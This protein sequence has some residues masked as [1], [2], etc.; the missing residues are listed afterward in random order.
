MHSSFVKCIESLKQVMPLCMVWAVGSQTVLLNL[1][2]ASIELYC[3]KSRLNVIA[4]S[5]IFFVEEFRF[6]KLIFH[7]GR[8]VFRRW[9]CG[10]ATAAWSR[11]C[12]NRL[13]LCRNGVKVK[14]GGDFPILIEE[15]AAF[16]SILAN[17]VP[18]NN[19]ESF[20]KTLF[21]SIL[22]NLHLHDLKIRLRK[23]FSL[24]P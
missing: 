17:L 6:D 24:P 18:V 15:E 11:Y 1:Q 10:A 5:I 2:T 20:E 22:A 16:R 9:G 13:K 19:Y 4:I 12:A 14:Y 7:V 8:S 23:G 3:P 21:R